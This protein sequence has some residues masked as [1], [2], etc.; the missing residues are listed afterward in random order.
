MCSTQSL[1]YC[2]RCTNTRCIHVNIK[3][4]LQWSFHTIVLWFS[5]EP[6]D[7]SGRLWELQS[8]KTK[9]WW[10]ESLIFTVPSLEH[11]SKSR[12]ASSCIFPLTLLPCISVLLKVQNVRDRI[13]FSLFINF[14]QPVWDNGVHEFQWKF[15]TAPGSSSVFRL[16]FASDSNLGNWK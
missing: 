14:L 10:F 9:T 13:F 15:T 16:S 5:H 7:E 6:L 11:Y 2:R 1:C 4:A 8:T 12:Q 3:L